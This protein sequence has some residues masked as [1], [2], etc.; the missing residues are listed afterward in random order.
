MCNIHF[1]TLVYK[2]LYTHTHK[3]IN[4]CE[5]HNVLKQYIVSSPRE[6][7]IFGIHWLPFDFDQVSR[8]L[9]GHGNSLGLG[10]NL[11][12]CWKLKI[13]GREKNYPSKS[14]L[15]LFNFNF[16]KFQRGRKA[17]YNVHLVLN[18]T[19]KKSITIKIYRMTNY[20]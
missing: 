18:L 11:I 4:M 17:F 8:Y 16:K 13:A 19:K 5:I 9:H 10:D 15:S 2:S 7:Y 12:V 1:Y 14:L 20:N 6:F 3:Y